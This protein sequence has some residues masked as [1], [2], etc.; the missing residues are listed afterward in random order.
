MKRRH[1]IKIE[2]ASAAEKDRWERRAKTLGFK[3]SDYIR[4]VV[5]REL[6]LADKGE[7]IIPK[8]EDLLAKAGD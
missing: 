3:T 5:R 4:R 7:V 1:F 8:A 2:L 6:E